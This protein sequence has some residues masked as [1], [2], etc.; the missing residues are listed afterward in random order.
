MELNVGILTLITITLINS[1]I[2]NIWCIE[3]QQY[4]GVP[5]MR[6][7][8]HFSPVPSIIEQAFQIFRPR[9]CAKQGIQSPYRRQPEQHEKMVWWYVEQIRRLICAKSI[10]S[11]IEQELYVPK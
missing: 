11:E 1:N 9:H 7:A 2:N 5:E 6:Q 8:Q 10:A 3:V 4:I